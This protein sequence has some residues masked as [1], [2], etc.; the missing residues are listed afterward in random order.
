MQ[1]TLEF[2]LACGISAGTPVRVSAYQNKL[3]HKAQ[4]TGGTGSHIAAWHRCIVVPVP[5]CCVAVPCTTALLLHAHNCGQL[6]RLSCQQLC[7]SKVCPLAAVNTASLQ[8][9][10]SFAVPKAALLL[11]PTLPGVSADQRSAGG[12]S[13]RRGPHPR[14]GETLPV[15]RCMRLLPC[16]EGHLQRQCQCACRSW[17]QVLCHPPS[18]PSAQCCRARCMNTASCMR[19][20]AGSCCTRTC[21]RPTSA[22]YTTMSPLLQVTAQGGR[23]LAAGQC[24]GA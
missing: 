6:Q 18:S 24:A 17:Q 2:P 13:H 4:R 22:G 1:A 23:A 19:D 3:R 16:F 20:K 12:H 11:P 14:E 5:V 8:A 21:W 9:A 15:M 7:R 10:N